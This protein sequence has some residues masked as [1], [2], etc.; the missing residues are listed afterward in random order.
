MT[1]RRKFLERTALGTGS[2]LF[3]PGLLTSCTDHRIPDPGTPVVGSPVVGAGDGPTFD[4]ND[5]LKIVVTNG[6]NKVPIVGEILSTLLEIL[7]PESAKDVWG[8]VKEQVEAVVNQKISDAVYRLVEEDLKGLNNVLTLYVN[9]TKNGNAATKLTVWINT[10]FAFVNAL[11]HFQPTQINDAILALPLFAQFANMYLSVLRDGLI[12]GKSWGMTDG[13]LEQLS[14]DL[15]S[16]IHDF[17]KYVQ[18]TAETGYANLKASAPQNGNTCDPYRTLNP[19]ERK[20]TLAALDYT[21]NWPNYDVT[22]YPNGGYTELTR[23]IYSDVV[24]TCYGNFTPQELSTMHPTIA[25]PTQLPTQITVWGGQAIIATKVTYP[26]DGG[27]GGVTEDR[28]GVPCCEGTTDG[29]LGGTVTIPN[30][31]TNPIVK[32][33]YNLDQLDAAN[34]LTFVTVQFVFADGT[35]SPMFGG[36]DDSPFGTGRQKTDWPTPATVTFKDHAL[37][38]IHSNN[39]GNGDLKFMAGVA[40][41]FKYEPHPTST[42]RALRFLYVRSPQE[43]SVAEFVSVHSTQAVATNLLSEEAELK[44]A[45][46]A[47]WASL[48]AR[49]AAIK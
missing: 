48:Q 11:P 17:V 36:R 22:E 47:Y 44:A 1:N 37:S 3:L 40:L 14:T 5:D 9:E 31:L 24:G 26:K 43:Q 23:Q 35:Y 38:L 8:E 6:L 13:D 19:Y 20:M 41:G 46:Q 15:K 29:P 21:V 33:I 10:R 12:G 39:Y 28:Q 16:A 42:L 45:R 30:P 32:V 49:A 2:V 34:D 7:W 4:V 25:V 27:P 18:D